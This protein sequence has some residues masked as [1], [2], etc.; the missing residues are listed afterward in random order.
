M[1]FSGKYCYA[2]SSY[3]CFLS[4]P[5]YSSRNGVYQEMKAEVT[6]IPASHLIPEGKHNHTGKTMVLLVLL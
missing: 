2:N 4:D 1:Y 3:I 6:E 5:P